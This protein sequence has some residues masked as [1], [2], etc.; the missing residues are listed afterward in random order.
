MTPAFSAANDS[1]ETSR[2]AVRILA[3]FT[4]AHG[5]F[6]FMQQSFAVMLPAIKAA[7]GISPIQIGALMTAKE[8]AMGVS[9]LPGG[10]LS[11]RLRRFREIIMAACMALFGLSWLLIGFASVYSL[12]ILGIV[13]VS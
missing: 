4:I 5:I 8:I 3:G 2:G 12:L 1:V 13:F 7:F 11:D 6:H 9:S 10:V